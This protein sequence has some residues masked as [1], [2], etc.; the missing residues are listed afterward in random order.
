MR[1][2]K[3]KLSLNR[4]KFLQLCGLGTA[5]IAAT[6]KLGLKGVSAFTDENGNAPQDGWY[7]GQCKMCMQG[8][9]LM[10]VH[11]INGVVVEIEGDKR[12]INNKGTLCARGNAG[13]MNLYNPW[14]VKAPMKRT[15]PKKGLNE[16]PGWVEISWEE[17][18]DT[19]S[20]KMK[21]IRNDDP[22]KLVVVSGFG[23]MAATEGITHGFHV[24]FGTP[25]DFRTHGEAC[26]YHFGPVYVQGA[27]PE[28][29]QDIMRTEY[30]LVFGKGLGPNRALTSNGSMTY[31]D[32]IENGTEV[33][34]VDPRCSIEASKSAQW[35][36]IKPGTDCAFLLGMLHSIF[37]EVKRFD[38][39]FVKNRTNGPYLI[40]KDG[41]YVRDPETG[42]PLLWDQKEG[43]ARTFDKIPPMNAALEGTYTVN[44]EKAVPGFQLI[45]ESV[46]KYTPKWAEGVTTVPAETIKEA[47]RKFMSHAHIGETIKIGH[48]KMPF[49][50]VG[51][52]YQRGSYQHTLN[53][54]R[55]DLVARIIC[56]LAGCLDVPGGLNTIFFPHPGLFKPDKDGVLEKRHEA[57]PEPWEWPP[58]TLQQRIFYPVSHTLAHLGARAINNPEEY[59]MEYEPDMILTYGG[60]PFHSMFDP[61]IWEKAYA[62]TPFN[63]AICDT[64]AESAIMSDILMPEHSFMERDYYEWSVHESSAPQGLARDDTKRLM[65][66]GRRDASAIRNP[67]NTREGDEILYELADRV[68]FLKGPGGLVEWQSNHTNGPYKLNLDINRRYTKK[69]MAQIR[70]T[71][72]FLG[73]NKKLK[74]INDE[75]GPHFT[76][77]GSGPANYNYFFYPENRTRHPM[78]MVVLQ[79]IEYSLRKNMKE[80]RVSY[81]P[82]WQGM[83]DYWW[84]A[85]DPLPS[86][87]P[88]RETSAPPEYDLNA[89]NYKTVAA[90]FKVGDVLGNPLVHEVFKKFDPYE[91][92]ILLNSSTARKKGLKDGEQVIVESRYGKSKGRLKLTGLIHPQ[93]VGIPGTHGSRSSQENPLTGEGAFFNSICS[94]RQEDGAVDPITGGIEQGPAVKIYKA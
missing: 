78:Y 73:K 61:D 14:R 46:K 15:N 47:A 55:G 57:L 29:A 68:G 11:V 8:D 62:K 94:A 1:E 80:A 76:R 3:N 83:M 81:I 74:D 89:I 52:Q 19:V 34:I 88:S 93:A 26:A 77:L 10:R 13:I 65:V 82:G 16:D 22:R 42:K 23:N 33:V 87:V 36:P 48:M 27:F 69:E 43:R 21:A 45:K 31:M 5:A 18:F 90:P 30:M 50:P 4:R 71:K 75:S 67:Y 60:N 7:P 64:Y 70:L 41:L 44:G 2:E 92:A 51:I 20:K 39:W 38:E 91:Y 17:A 59:K 28:S 66:F 58:Q 84:K 35:I 85:W 79:E 12:A 9:C 49:R 86:W 63:V 6:G 25:N 56:E 54:P 40:G 72:C 37:Y 53:G 24:T 32:A